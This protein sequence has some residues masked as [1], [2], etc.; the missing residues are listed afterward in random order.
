MYVTAIAGDGTVGPDVIRLVVGAELGG[1][2]ALLRLATLYLFNQLLPDELKFGMH[3]Y[4]VEGIYRIAAYG[5]NAARFMRFL[6]VTAPSAGGEYLSEKFN[7]FVEEIRVE[8]QFGNI[9]LTDKGHIAADLTISEAGIAVKYNV[10][11]SDKI[12]L[13]FGSKDRS[14]AELAARLLRLVG[15]SAEVKR[16]VDEE[17]WRVV[18]TTDSLADGRKE[19]RDAIAEI[20]M[21]AAKNDWVDEKKAE[22][23]LEKL[24]KGRVL[25]EGWPKYNVRLDHHGALLVRFGSPNPNSIEREAQRFRKMGLEEGK[26][27]T[28]KMPEE[29][30]GGYVLILKEGL[31][32]AAWL[33]VH[34]SG[35]QQRWAA[36]FVEYI[37]QRAWE[38]GREVYEKAREIIEEGKARGSLTL[39]GFENKVEV[40]GREHVVKVIGG[41]AEHEERQGGRKLLKIWI[42]AEVDGVRSECTIT[43]GRYSRNKA[44]GY[45]YAKAD[46]PGGREAD[47]ERFAA[48]IKALTG[49]EPGVYLRSDGR[50]MMECY[51]GHLEGFTRYAEL[52]DDIEKW[53]EETRGR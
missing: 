50:I 53:L 23:W 47:A 36:E 52:V 12:E 26:H 45:A 30:R 7:E 37:L 27:L 10:Y 33:S 6:A 14:R 28:V 5:E 32:R 15:V 43:Y 8:V 25:K 42:I 20:I 24:E 40:N 38:A 17:I 11:L 51:E 46:A 19:L 49:R 31:K 39:K 9:R 4:A 34:G 44:V 48:V 22:R 18:A 35:E 21:K 16:K 3:T 41:G 2:A 29:G 1:G 13:C